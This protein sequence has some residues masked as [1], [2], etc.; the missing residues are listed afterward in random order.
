MKSLGIKNK[1]TAA[2][3]REEKEE[4]DVHFR[5]FTSK[6]PSSLGV[7]ALSIHLRAKNKSGTEKKKLRKQNFSR[8][9]SFFFICYTHTHKMGEVLL[10]HTPLSYL[11][12]FLGN[13]FRS[14]EQNLF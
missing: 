13:F 1:R 4:R 8:L 10:F 6:I 14:L 2:R 3:E 9:S 7:C 5:V 12:S 11:P